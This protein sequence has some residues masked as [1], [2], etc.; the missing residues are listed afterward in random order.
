MAVENER[1]RENAHTRDQ[2]LRFGGGLFTSVDTDV[3]VFSFSSLCFSE[4]FHQ[5][6]AGLWRLG[7][8]R[9][10]CKLSRCLSEQNYFLSTFFRRDYTLT[11]P[12]QKF[13]Y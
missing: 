10:P 11:W 8:L 6:Q 12:D 7:Y 2:I 1:E 9:P 13:D 5:F 4:S 3:A